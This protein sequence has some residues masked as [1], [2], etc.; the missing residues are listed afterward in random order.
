MRGTGAHHLLDLRPYS[1]R[2]LHDLVRP[3][4]HDPPTFPFHCCRATRVG[5]DLKGVM[6]A[7]DLDHDFPRYAGEVREVGAN[8]MLAT[9]LRAAYAARSEEFPNL[10]FSA[11]AVATELTCPLGII[12]VSGHGP[13]T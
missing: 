13:L 4:A 7:I 2:I 9:E 1:L 6:I 11:A 10:A 12:V 5:L 8:C 3:E